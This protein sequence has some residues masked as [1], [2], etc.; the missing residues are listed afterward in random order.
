MIKH[1]DDDLMDLKTAF[2]TLDADTFGTEG[3][4]LTYQIIPI[5]SIT[6]QT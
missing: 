3:M 4:I 6:L 1:F 5:I 2:G